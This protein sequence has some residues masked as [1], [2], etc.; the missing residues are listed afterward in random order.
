MRAPILLEIGSR[1]SRLTIVA[2]APKRPRSNA[3]RYLCRCDCGCDTDVQGASLRY[4]HTRS[5]GC[6]RAEQIGAVGLR[7]THGHTRHAHR[8]R[9]YTSWTAMNARCTNPKTRGYE[10]YGAKGISVTKPWR[11]SFESFLNDLGERP[12]GHTL[13]RIDNRFG[14]FMANCR[15]A[16]PKEQAANR[17]K[18][19]SC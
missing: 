1:F 7:A 14:Y 6:L 10:R 16:T 12:V 4:G 15:W 19:A 17:R 11:D 3:V 2:R 5:C 13:D 9:T 8:S 18:P